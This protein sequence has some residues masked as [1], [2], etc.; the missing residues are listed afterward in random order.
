[1]RS[2]VR[3]SA[4][5]LSLLLVLT[6]LLPVAA[7]AAIHDLDTLA[8][9]AS[10]TGW[11]TVRGT[12]GSLFLYPGRTDEKRISHAPGSTGTSDQ[13]L[14][15]AALEQRL[16]STGWNVQRDSDGSLLLYPHVN[17]NTLA[18]PASEPVTT[19]PATL[20]TVE[21]KAET[22]V[23]DRVAEALRER[24]W[25]RVERNAAGDLLLYP[26]TPES[27]SQRDSRLQAGDE[28]VTIGGQGED[29]LGQLSRVLSERGWHTERAEDGSLLLFPA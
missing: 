7:N 4:R 6:A 26:R 1:M 8:I 23:L 2:S 27:D 16:V 5:V 28:I 29:R 11:R 3:Q 15:L 25:Q 9:A 21:P 24:G 18:E 20:A 17:R 13:D 19:R 22:D 12:D 14:P 10:D